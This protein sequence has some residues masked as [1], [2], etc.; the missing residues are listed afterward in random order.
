MLFFKKV[1]FELMYSLTL[2]IGNKVE[3]SHQTQR[4]NLSGQVVYLLR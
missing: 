1:I 4:V 2:Y 3:I